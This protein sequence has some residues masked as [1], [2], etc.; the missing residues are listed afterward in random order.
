M[1]PLLHKTPGI[2]VFLML[3]LSLCTGQSV[4]FKT[5]GT[6]QVPVN[7]QNQPVYFSI[8]SYFPGGGEIYIN[9]MNTDFSIAKGFSF[10]E[11]VGY[12]IN[13]FLS[14]ELNISYFSNAEKDFDAYPKP[15][16]SI[17]GSTNWNYKNIGLT[18]AIA[19]GHTFHKST[20]KINVFSGIGFSSLEV[21]ASLNN[22]FD[23]Y[24]FDKSISYSY[25]Y[26][27]EYLFRISGLFQ[28][29]ANIG[30][31]NLIYTPKHSE[32]T[33]STARDLEY[34]PVYQKEIDYV[35]EIKNYKSVNTEPEK[36][37][38]EALKL[39]SLYFGMGIKF[40]IAKHEK[41]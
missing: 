32:L 36:R 40:T 13:Y 15:V 2:F 8:S 18:P 24:T 41:K 20:L 16:Y 37:I 19:I 31:N 17:N 14:V 4:Y 35:K 23:K 39:N 30:L 34:M 27:L 12:N 6:Y 29:Y 3:Q 21:K 33:E 1:N 9:T 7:R 28:V 38:Q 26:G 5:G 25:G 11:I 10:Q 22:Y